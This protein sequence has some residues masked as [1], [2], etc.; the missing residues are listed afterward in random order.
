MQLGKVLADAEFKTLSYFEQFDEK[1]WEEIGF[2][3]KIVQKESLLELVA[4]AV[5]V[6]AGFVEMEM[7]VEGG[8]KDGGV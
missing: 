2:D 8:E 6:F 1:K 4:L 7:E 5:N 3:V